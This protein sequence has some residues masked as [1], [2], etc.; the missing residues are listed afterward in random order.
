MNDNLI[1]EKPVRE[2]SNFKDKVISNS[3]I[4]IALALF[5]VICAIAGSMLVT[6]SFKQTYNE[7]FVPKYNVEIAIDDMQYVIFDDDMSDSEK[8]SAIEDSIN[9]LEEELIGEK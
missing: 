1:E 5:G 7:M 9:T 6:S 8:L 3:I 2:S 4:A